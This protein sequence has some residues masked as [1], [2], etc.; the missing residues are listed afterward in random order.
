VSES[1]RRARRRR[2]RLDH[3]R[4]G[5]AIAGLSAAILFGAMF[6]PWYD[7]TV[8]SSTLQLI[9]L[10]IGRNAWQTLGAIPVLL[11]LVAAAAF[12]VMLLRVLRPEWKP[13]ISPGAIVAVLGGLAALLI[14]FRLV[15]PPSISVSGLELEV[16]PGLAAFVGLAA[17]FGIAYGGYRA[18]REAGSS[19]EAVAD[20]LQPRR[21]RPASRR[22]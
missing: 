9:I 1:R 11:A 17:A 3:L 16:T 5:E 21:A 4:R 6:F 19:F 20:S 7:V 15:V 12:G 22:R 8:V 10:D 18:M 2:L 13:A 14:L